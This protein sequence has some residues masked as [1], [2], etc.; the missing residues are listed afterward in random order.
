MSEFAT[1]FDADGIL[2][3]FMNSP[4]E[5]NG[6]KSTA[7]AEALVQAVRFG[8]LTPLADSIQAKVLEPVVFAA[9]R[10]GQLQKPVLI[11]SITDG[12]PTDSPRD[13]ILQVCDILVLVVMCYLDGEKAD[14]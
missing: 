12:E 1:L 10:S 4:Q 8:G 9:A 6:I 13:K 2:I 11:I 7:E 14:M 5:G 3:R